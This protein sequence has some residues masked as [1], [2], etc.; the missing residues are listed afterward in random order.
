MP[1]CAM[2]DRAVS[3][4]GKQLTVLGDGASALDW[5]LLEPRLLAAWSMDD[6]N[7]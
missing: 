2:Q 4:P 3:T 7:G 1:S 5:K 6:L